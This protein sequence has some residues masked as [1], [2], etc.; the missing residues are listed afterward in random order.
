MNEEGKQGSVLTLLPAR[1][2]FWAYVLYGLVAL[3][4]GSALVGFAAAELPLPGW[5]VVG[6]AVVTYLATPFS[7][8]AASNVKS[9]DP[10]A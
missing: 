10:S 6:T 3:A 8:I 9:G 1:V 5:L 7:T 2:R 4:A